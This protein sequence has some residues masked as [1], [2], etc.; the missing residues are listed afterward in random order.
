MTTVLRSPSA[1]ED[2][3]SYALSKISLS[4]S[5]ISILPEEILA[6][7]F[8]YCASED[9]HATPV[10]LSHVSFLWRRIATS[11]PRIWDTIYVALPSKYRDYVRT[12]TRLERSGAIPL[13]ITLLVNEIEDGDKDLLDKLRDHLWHCS[14]L[15]LKSDSHEIAPR[16]PGHQT[17]LSTGAS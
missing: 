10:L 5:P 9:P 11:T 14:R 6:Q 7:I 3:G 13:N 4:S 15:K 2:G 1:M 8:E 16:T 17:E 12:R